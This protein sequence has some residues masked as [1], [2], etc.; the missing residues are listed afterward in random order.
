MRWLLTIAFVL[1]SA[2]CF[3]DDDATVLL[4]GKAPDHPY[5][6]HMY[7]HTCGMLAK[8]VER[9]DG[10]QAVVSEGWPQD[11]EVLDGVDAIVVYATPAAEFLLD[12]AHRDEVT[13]MLDRGVGLVTIHWASSV[14]EANLARLGP[15]WMK[16]LGGTWVSNVGLHTGD[17]P[18]KQLVPEHPIS[19]GW[20]EY[21]LNDEYYLDPT[22]GEATP[23]LRVTTP[24]KTVV[25]GW[26]HERP[27]GGRAFATTL[28]HFYRN[29][30]REPFRRMITN[31]ILWTAGVEVPAQGADVALSD[32]DLALPPKPE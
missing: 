13:A 11:A 10:V 9:H 32:E 28:G 16:Y 17:S 21:D 27:D 12:G 7:M 5:A 18:L 8:C 23:L 31:G 30:Q 3:A 26:A 14:H 25:V 2:D 1:I 6:T 15:T 19:R 20:Q 24:G 29:F 4:I 22:I